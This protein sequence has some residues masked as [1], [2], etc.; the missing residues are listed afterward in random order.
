MWQ[1]HNLGILTEHRA[2]T[3][4]YGDRNTILSGTMSLDDCAFS[5]LATVVSRPTP[6]RVILDAGSK[7]FSSDLT[8]QDG[9]G[10][11]PAYPQAVLYRLTEEH[12]MVDV[13]NCEYRPQIGERLQVIP[14]HCCVVSNLF[15]RVAVVRDEHVE[16]FWSIAARGKLQ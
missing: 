13:S 9:Y 8:S 10:L 3:Y 14:N 15:D 16:M 12:G 6:E 5:V 2:G 4:V 1:T 11:L 7:T